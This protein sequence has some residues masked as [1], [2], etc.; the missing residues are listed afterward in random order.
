MQTDIWLTEHTWASSQ[1]PKATPGSIANPLPQEVDTISWTASQASG[2]PYAR[3]IS[4]RE[5]R[6]RHYIGV[7]LNPIDRLRWW[8]LRP[9]HIE[10]IL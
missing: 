5:R 9:G 4:S 3:L 7:S 1:L 2:S 10:F 8:L 6:K